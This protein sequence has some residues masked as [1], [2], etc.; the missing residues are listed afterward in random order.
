MTTLPRAGID[1]ALLN[2]CYWP[3]VRR[4]SERFI[5]DLASGLIE[6]GHRP[7]LITSHK[8]PPS[9]TNEDGLEVIRVPRP[10][11]GLLRDRMF[12]S[13]LTHVPLSYAALRLRGGDLAHAMFATDACAAA[14][15][16]ERTGR[17]SVFSYM[18]IPERWWLTGR[19][20][21]LKTTLRAVRDCSAVV[22]LSRT[23]AE[24]FRRNLGVEARVISPGVD[25]TAF[26]PGGSR[27]P[28]PTIF[29]ASDAT[30]PA[31]R[32]PDL[33]RAFRIVRRERPAARL[34]LSWPPDRRA[35][36]TIVAGE[37]G[38][39]LVEVDDRDAL[40]DA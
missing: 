30:E 4:G 31:K 13:Y 27:A 6:D 26:A 24:S 36:E 18:G 20:L 22:A 35:A 34:L 3:E 1:V 12:E 32:V 37:D 19:R 28:D 29:C 2:P 15:W 23:A 21:R 25:T 38:V 16:T 17:P 9:R 39:S 10:P 11:E 8:G 33:V 7:H 40:R 5:R 14:R